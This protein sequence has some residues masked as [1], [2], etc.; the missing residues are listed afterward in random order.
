MP[1]LA[2]LGTISSAR[3]PASP[4]RNAASFGI[5]ECGESSSSLALC[6]GMEPLAQPY[7][8]STRIFR[9]TFAWRLDTFA[10]GPADNQTLRVA[11]PL[12]ARHF[13]GA[14]KSNSPCRVSSLT[15][16]DAFRVSITRL[17]MSRWWAR[18]QC[19]AFRAVGVQA[20]AV[21][22]VRSTQSTCVSETSSASI[23]L[24]R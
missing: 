17:P 18:A 23:L 21:R 13:P 6:S 15:P 9:V 22:A 24:F 10:L 16:V 20:Q 7:A 2:P 3:T 11:D 12:P 14:V 5:R 19:R 4:Q 1:L 8:P